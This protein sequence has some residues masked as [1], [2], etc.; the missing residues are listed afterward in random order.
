VRDICGAR[1][2]QLP[3]LMLVIPLHGKH[4]GGIAVPK[5]IGVDDG[6]RSAV[7]AG[8]LRK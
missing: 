2:A 7:N 4:S 3:V 8:H 6:D 5:I 1:S